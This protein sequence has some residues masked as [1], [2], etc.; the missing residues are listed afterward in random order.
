MS[1][2]VLFS[3]RAFN[4]FGHIINYAEELSCFFRLLDLEI[5]HK[6]H[7]IV[8]G[9]LVKRLR[10]EYNPFIAI[11]AHLISKRTH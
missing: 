1:S 2:V 4:D 10:A 9:S 7:D 11:L 6:D 8:I 5:G 3:T